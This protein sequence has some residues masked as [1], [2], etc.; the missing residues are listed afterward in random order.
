MKAWPKNKPAGEKEKRELF[1]HKGPKDTKTIK[2]ATARLTE[3][4]SS[5]AQNFHFNCIFLCVPCAFAVKPFR[6]FFIDHV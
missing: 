6:D 4:G 2:M 3:R 1:N 5:Q